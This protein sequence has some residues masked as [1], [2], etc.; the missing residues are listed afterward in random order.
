[1]TITHALRHVPKKLRMFDSGCG[2][3][4]EEWTYRGAMFGLHQDEGL[5]V[6]TVVCMY[7]DDETELPDTPTFDSAREQACNWIDAQHAKAIG[8]EPQ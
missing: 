4:H 2:C 7:E 1:M 3:P 5:D 8:K 6:Q